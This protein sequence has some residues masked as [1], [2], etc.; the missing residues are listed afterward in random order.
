[1]KKILIL[2]TTITMNLSAALAGEIIIPTDSQSRA[3]WKSIDVIGKIEDLE[4]IKNNRFE[5]D[6]IACVFEN[7]YACSI[8]TQIN[9]QRK[10]VVALDGAQGF[11]QAMV[12]A[13]AKTSE[14]SPRL[15]LARVACEKSEN[16]TVSCVFEVSEYDENR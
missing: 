3:I 7:Y 2:L 12:N 9:N 11:I 5:I 14:Y 6:N 13:G 10:L 16:L 1:M 4:I 8:Y 15:D